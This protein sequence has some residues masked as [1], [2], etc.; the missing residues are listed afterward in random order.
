MSLG[1]LLSNVLSKVEYQLFFFVRC[2]YLIIEKQRMHFQWDCKTKKSE[3]YF[4]KDIFRHC[5]IISRDRLARS[6]YE[7]KK[8]KVLLTYFNIPQRHHNMTGLKNIIMNMGTYS[9]LFY[10]NISILIIFLLNRRG[11]YFRI[12]N[13]PNFM[14]TTVNIIHVMFAYIF[15][16]QLQ[17]KLPSLSYEVDLFLLQLLILRRHLYILNKSIVIC[18]IL[19]EL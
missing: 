11:N 17:S 15:K 2:R 19:I 8:F 12:Q 16:F 18:S 3:N 7:R 4:V 1:C 5:N 6:V 9:P 10:R 14:P 13:Q